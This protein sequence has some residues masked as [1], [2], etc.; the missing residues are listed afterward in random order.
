MLSLFTLPEGHVQEAQTSYYGGVV[1]VPT[2]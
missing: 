2:S 1:E